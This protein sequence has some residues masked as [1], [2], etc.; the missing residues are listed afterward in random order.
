MI[1]ILL[2]ILA[3]TTLTAG[4]VVSNNGNSNNDK[5]D[6]FADFLIRTVTDNSSHK[7]YAVNNKGKVLWEIAGNITD[8]HS[9]TPISKTKALLKTYNNKLYISTDGWKTF[10]EIFTWQEKDGYTLIT[11]YTYARSGIMSVRTIYSD[12]DTYEDSYKFHESY[13]NGSTWTALQV[14][15]NITESYLSLTG[16]K[17][18]REFYG[19]HNLKAVI[20]VLYNSATNSSQYYII[21]NNGTVKRQ[22]ADNIQNKTTLRI[23]DDKTAYLIADNKLYRSDDGYMKFQPVTFPDVEGY[24]FIGFGL[25]SD[26]KD[27]WF[28]MD[29]TANDPSSENGSGLYHAKGMPFRIDSNDPS[30]KILLH[31]YVIDSNK[32]TP[33]KVEI[34]ENGKIF[35]NLDGTVLLKPNDNVSI[36]TDKGITFSPFFTPKVIKGYTVSNIYLSY[37]IQGVAGARVIYENDSSDSIRYYETY[38]NGKTWT[39]VFDNVY[40]ASISRPY[41]IE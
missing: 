34:K 9:F 23:M 28:R 32:A 17:V 41:F 37:G 3:L 29:Y 14:D 6:P 33:R 5:S 19:S 24:T 11:G 22:I 40:S 26:A 1:K 10:K 30:S 31:N 12:N 8:K 21:D 20:R 2:G 13:D 4:L 25:Y 18:T 16:N 7:F 35:P 38:D 15:D 27:M 36:S 39:L